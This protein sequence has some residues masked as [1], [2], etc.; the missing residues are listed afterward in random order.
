[1]ENSITFFEINNFSKTKSIYN[2]SNNQINNY[3]EFLQFV[4]DQNIDYIL[5]VQKLKTNIKISFIDKSIIDNYDLNFIIEDFNISENYILVSKS[6]FN[7]K[8]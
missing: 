6:Q 3:N 4:K 5:N 7:L 1:M 2:C 8:F